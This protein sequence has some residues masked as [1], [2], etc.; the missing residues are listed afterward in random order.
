M[1]V[2]YSSKGKVK[3]TLRLQDPSKMESEK[4]DMAINVHTNRVLTHCR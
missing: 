3:G 1:S 2:Y 4:A